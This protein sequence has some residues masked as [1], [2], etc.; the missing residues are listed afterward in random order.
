MTELAR[1][2]LLWLA[3]IAIAAGCGSTN[4]P[5]T[6]VDPP[7]PVLNL[8]KLDVPEAGRVYHGVLPVGT[9]EPDSDASPRT[10]DEY[11]QT[12]GRKVAYVYFSTDWF[13]SRA[14]PAN[15]ARWIRDRRSVPFIRLMMRSQRRPLVTDPTFTLDRI[16]AGEFDP[17]LSAWADAARQFATPLV[18]EYGTEV[19]GDWN[20]WSAP[21]NGG[22]NVGPG[23]FKQAYRHVVAV[24]RGRGAS[25]ITWA[26][27]Y[28]AQNYPEDPRN[29]PASYYPGDDV[30]DWVGISAYGSERS[31]D[32]R[33]PT[34]RSLVEDML[35]QLHAATASKPLFIFEFGITNNNPRCAAAPWVLAALADLLGGRWPQVRGFAWWQ[36]R[37]NNDGAAGSDMLVQDDPAVAAAF[38]SALT[39]PSAPSVVD[40]PLLR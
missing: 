40:A 7:P 16:I 5:R 34:F 36:E 23:K 20:P 6:S 25:N 37:W 13:R 4:P 27:H 3:A 17:D 8:Q 30:V 29:V 9:T 2:T 32:D 22:L 14:F 39:G 31:N 33:C 24:M 26:L 35:P 19:N 15:T 11:E 21:Y 18:V 28:N 1:R 10:L 38:R 12:V